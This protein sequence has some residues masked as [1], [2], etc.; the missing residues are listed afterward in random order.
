MNIYKYILN[1]RQIPGTIIDNDFYHVW[2]QNLVTLVTNIGYW[3]FYAASLV[4]SIMYL[5][6]LPIILLG[7]VKMDIK[8]IPIDYLPDYWPAPKD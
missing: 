6:C 5:I 7:E 1:T 8:S 4:P 3:R 2:H